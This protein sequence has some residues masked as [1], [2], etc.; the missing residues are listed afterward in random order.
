MTLNDPLANVLN[1]IFN[2]EKVAKSETIVWPISNVIKKVLELMYK[3]KYIGQV[4]YI[5]DNKGGQIQIKLIGKINKCGV[6][7]PRYP[8]KLN[9]YE[10]FE[11]RYLPAKD[12]GFL[13]VS[14][15]NGI[16]THFEAKEKKLGGRLLAYVY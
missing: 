16:M 4:K 9:D 5:E 13:I 2:A 15:S 10:K 11:K 8:V 7:K 12:F 6:I 14:T 1:T 3:R